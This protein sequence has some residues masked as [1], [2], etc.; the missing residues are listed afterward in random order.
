EH[1]SCIW[2]VLFFVPNPILGRPEEGKKGPWTGDN[3]CVP[4][5]AD[6]PLGHLYR[7]FLHS[8]IGT[9]GQSL[10]HMDRWSHRYYIF[11]LTDCYIE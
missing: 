3:C 1:L 11:I 5:M 8:D 9:I 10:N 6:S 2:Q 4:Q 7:G